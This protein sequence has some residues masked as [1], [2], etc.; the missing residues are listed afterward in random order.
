M[1]TINGCCELKI[2][3]S[4]YASSGVYKMS[5]GSFDNSV[6]VYC[7]M[8]TDGGGWI[9]IQRNKKDSSVSFNRKWVN[10]ENG[11][12]NLNTEFWHGLSAM[13][14]LTQRGQWEMRVDYQFNN[15]TW[16]YYHYNQF[17]V[18]SASEEYPLTVG[19]FTGVGSD[20][21]NYQ[22]KPHN[23][24]KFSTPDNDNDKS[25]SNCAASYKSGWW[26]NSCFEITINRQPPFIRDSGDVLFSEMKIRPKDCITQ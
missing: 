8:T 19:G 20:W 3:S 17:S 12:G 22:Y 26:Y 23:G 24:M 16:S 13:H 10:Y 9:V 25:G 18:G 21:F 4:A 6:N 11:F 14:C 15:K 1:L 7:D 5:K 2:F